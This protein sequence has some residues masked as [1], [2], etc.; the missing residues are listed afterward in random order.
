MAVRDAPGAG[1]GSGTA[2]AYSSLTVPTRHAVGRPVPTRPAARTKV[3]RSA[4]PW[5]RIVPPLTD[6]DSHMRGAT[7]TSAGASKRERATT[8]QSPRAVGGGVC[9]AGV[10]ALLAACGPGPDA[11]AAAGGSG[12]D[13]TAGGSS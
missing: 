5:R 8:V 6:E 3:M 9:L 2:S 7:A 13:V 10:L 12:S 1:G 11:G 4:H